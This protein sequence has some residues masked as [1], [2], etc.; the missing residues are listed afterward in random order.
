MP[1][2]AYSTG[3]VAC[4]LSASFSPS[5]PRG[6]IRSTTPSCVASWRSSSRSPPATIEIDAAGSPADATASERHGGQHRVRV[7]RHR[8]AAQH[9]RVARLEA[10]RR[11][12]D[13]HV[14]PRLVDDGDTPSGTRTL[15]SVEPVAEPLAL[16]HLA[17]RVG[18]RRDPPHVRRRSRR[19]APRSAS[20]GRS[21]PAR[22][23]PPAPASRSRSFASRISASRDSSASAIA[24]SAASRVP[25]SARARTRE[26]SFAAA[27][28]CGD[29]GGPG[30][31]RW[32]GTGESAPVTP[33]RSS[34][35]APP[36][37][38][39]AAGARG[40]SSVFIPLTRRSSV[41]RVVDD[42]LA[43]R[44]RRRSPLTAPRPRRRPGSSPSTSTMPTGSRLVPRSRSAR[45]APA[46][47]T[48]RPWVGFAYLSQSL[49]L[50]T[51]PLLRLEA[52]A[53]RLAREAPV[54]SAPGR[55]P[56]TIAAGMPAAV[57]ISDAT[58]FDRMPPDPSGELDAPISSSSSCSKSLT[59]VTSGA[60]GIDP[61]VGGVKAR[62]CRSGGAARRRPAGS[63]PARRGSR[64]RR[65][66]SRRWSSC[67]S[68]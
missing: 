60:V 22:G 12:V 2:A 29:G 59:S 13:R 6:M 5:P 52:R 16:D 25:V 58:T 30:G 44:A 11:A 66:R 48:I 26:A 42:P 67:R 14:R 54:R 31:H 65:T 38:S 43:D 17:D 37:R 47:T 34:R 3:T 15:R 68:R 1:D 50:E 21:A 10:Q 46:S 55:V 8:R 23:R 62:R 41:G 57:A 4:S 39:R 32:K 27:Q 61:R 53:L 7:R 20:A 9:D 64:C 33:A 45:A 28:I 35:G 18:Q 49:K 19:A 40:R 36:P 51:R 56:F 63:P 24:S